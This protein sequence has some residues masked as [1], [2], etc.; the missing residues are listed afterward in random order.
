MPATS[1]MLPVPIGYAHIN[2]QNG[3]KTVFPV[4][5]KDTV[6]N[7]EDNTKQATG[8][9]KTLFSRFFYCQNDTCTLKS[10]MH[11]M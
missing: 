11:E 3:I 9:A 4:Y 1:E 5:E 6:S 10:F 2:Y 8:A 7:R